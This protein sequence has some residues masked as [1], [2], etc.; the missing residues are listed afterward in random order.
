MRDLGR[1]TAGL[2]LLAGASFL[3][4]ALFGFDADDPSFNRATSGPVA[5]PAGAA[6]AV[7]AD[8]LLQTFGRPAGWCRSWPSSGASGWPPTAGW[9]GRGCRSWPCPWRS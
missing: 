9:S 2:L 7:A 3:A 1:R 4:L 6:G 5:N 8:L